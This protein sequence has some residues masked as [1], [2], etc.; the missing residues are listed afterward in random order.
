MCPIEEQKN[1]HPE[2]QVKVQMKN[3]LSTEHG[4]QNVLYKRRTWSK[5]DH[6]QQ[7][8]SLFNHLQS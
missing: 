3:T 1:N 6:I 5:E 4:Y 8:I 2:V 7:K